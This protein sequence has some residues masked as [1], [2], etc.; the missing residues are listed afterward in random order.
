MCAAP[1]GLI[2]QGQVEAPAAPAP[3]PALLTHVDGWFVWRGSFETKDLAKSAGLRFNGDLRRWETRF[4]ETASRLR[5]YA[6]AAALAAMD[7]VV[8]AAEAS[9]A[10][11]VDA[12]PEAV[13]AIPLPD[14]PAGLSLMPFQAAGVRAILASEGQGR[15]SWLLGDEMGL[16][17]TVQAL[18]LIASWG[19]P[20]LVVCPASLRRNWAREAIKWLPGRRVHIIQNGKDAIPDDADVLI[21]SYEGATKRATEL[22][23]S[24]AVLVCD[25]SHAVKNREAKRTQ[26]VCGYWDTKTKS[27]V[28]GLGDN[29][30]RVLLLT[31][32][33]IL[34]R[35]VELWTSLEVLGLARQFGGFM[36]YAKCYCAAKQSAYGWDVSGASNLEQLQ[37]RIRASGQFI[38]RLKADVL[39]ELP[40][41]TRQI[42]PLEGSSRLFDRERAILDSIASAWKSDVDGLE[43]FAVSF[44]EASLIR[45]KQAEEKVPAVLDYV[46]QA[47]ESVDSL[48]VFAHHRDVIDQICEGLNS[49]GIAAVKLY[50]GMSDAEKQAAVDA[51][52][53][54]KAKVFV[55][56]IVAAG[57]G[58]TLTRSST[59]I[60]A[61][62]DWRPAFLLQAEDR[63]HRIGQRDAVLSQLL[64]VDGSF[65]SYL[66]KMIVEK[67]GVVET[68]LDA[69]VAIAYDEQ[70]VAREQERIATEIAAQ[71]EAEARAQALAAAEAALTPEERAAR[72]E[73]EAAARKAKVAEA[74]RDKLA[75]RRLLRLG[76]LG[77]SDL[78]QPCDP[79]LASAI[80]E[81]CAYLAAYDGDHAFLE[82]GVGF[83]KSDSWYGHALALVGVR[84][85]G[86]A[87]AAQAM[88][89]IYSQTQLPAAMVAACGILP[90]AKEGG[91]GCATPCVPRLA[92]SQPPSGS[93]G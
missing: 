84:T 9:R 45:R 1:A 88:L 43:D 47:C 60:F 38:R 16:G 77:R 55:G 76:A 59:V 12:L 53:A 26:A 79:S 51:F 35:P 18:V 58:L 13:A 25:E 46:A 6:D 64:V 90:A 75:E 22:A 87:L 44:E 34:N 14:L 57:V 68:A 56:S 86:Q 71:A 20:V 17:K 69:N 66:A 49:N 62:L 54:G 61:E 15:R 78:A 4:A 30:K 65:D 73:A 83:S 3:A 37:T 36:K 50:G 28:N 32:T 11:S 63:C 24:W 92:G 5:D 19:G 40:P 91:E 81:A 23:R 80:Q 8:Q 2:G 10:A 72:A 70:L 33:P 89:R 7:S 67:M 31:G 52:Q 41:K 74:Q 21:V 48:V 29:A 93:N 85:V 39:T 27:H 42:V 82:N